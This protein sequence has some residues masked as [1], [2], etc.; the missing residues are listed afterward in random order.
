MKEVFSANKDCVLAS[1]VSTDKYY[2]VKGSFSPK[3]FISR[4]NFH[5]GNFI[6]RCS[7]CL[8]AG[9][10]WPDFYSNCLTTVIIR[11]L[12]SKNEQYEIFEFDTAKELFAWLAE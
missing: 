2:G 7:K 3:G 1:E 8:T 12:E 11:M 6:P 4:E 10:N 9:N 5:S